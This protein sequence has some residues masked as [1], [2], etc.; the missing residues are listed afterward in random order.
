M[1]SSEG[2]K[3]ASGATRRKAEETRSSAATLGVLLEL[4]GLGATMF[5]TCVSSKSSSGASPGP[6][7]GNGQWLSCS[8]SFFSSSY[9]DRRLA[10]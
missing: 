9:S 8:F 1:L 6:P 7:A 3:D 5:K 2:S 10:L 4:W